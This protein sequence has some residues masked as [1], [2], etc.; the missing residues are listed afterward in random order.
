[1]TGSLLVTNLGV[2]GVV[3][4]L[5]AFESSISWQGFAQR[6]ATPS[7]VLRTGLDLGLSHVVHGMGVSLHIHNSVLDRALSCYE[8]FSRLTTSCLSLALSPDM[9]V[10]L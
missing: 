3:A 9:K 8:G 7:V 4:Q 2:L 1:M 10:V 5:E 6:K